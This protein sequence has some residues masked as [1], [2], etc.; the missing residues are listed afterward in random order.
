MANSTYCGWCP[1]SVGT[2]APC[3]VA[4]QSETLRTRYPR[5]AG[6][7]LRQIKTRP[8]CGRRSRNGTPRR[9][10]SLA[11]SALPVS[12]IPKGLCPPALGCEERA[13]Q[14]NRVRESSTPTGLCHPVDYPSA[15]KTR[16]HLRV[17]R[18]KRSGHCHGV[19]GLGMEFRLQ[20]AGREQAWWSGEFSTGPT[21]PPPHR[22]KPELHTRTQKSA[23]ACGNRTSYGRR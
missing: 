3:R 6:H 16:A 8:C 20:A 9:S 13:T 12:P 19:A 22:L 11:A 18:T 5:M 1:K 14:G 10:C 15:N 2:G 17:V 23:P 21:Q 4:A 7:R